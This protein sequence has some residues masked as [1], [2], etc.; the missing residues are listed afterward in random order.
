MPDQEYMDRVDEL[1]AQETEAA[2]RQEEQA[3]LTA[4]EEAQRLATEA[5]L[6]GG[7]AQAP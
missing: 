7:Q 4:G 2:I 6:L 5:L 1:E 3:R